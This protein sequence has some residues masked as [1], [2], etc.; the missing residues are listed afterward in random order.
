MCM[1]WRDIRFP[2]D[3]AYVDRRVEH[4]VTETYQWV[5]PAKAAQ[6]LHITAEQLR[7]CEASLPPG[8][9][10][11]T[12]SGHHRYRADLLPLAIS[13]RE[14]QPPASEQPAPADQ[15]ISRLH[16][17][18]WREVSRSGQ[19]APELDCMVQVS[20]QA[21]RCGAQREVVRRRSWL[22]MRTIAIQPRPRRKVTLKS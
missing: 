7:R 9:V 17:H 1:P 16:L 22:G 5:S 4:P 14:V 11:V 19:W 13:V 6:L 18:R 2:G 12:H 20:A 8:C 15:P 3:P 21:C 10:G